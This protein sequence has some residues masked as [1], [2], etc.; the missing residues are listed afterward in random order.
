MAE[1]GYNGWTNYE[2]WAVFTWLNNEET[3]Y[4]RLR[5][6]AR[7]EGPS[8]TEKDKHL[9]VWI[10]AMNPFRDAEGS[11]YSDLLPHA[12]GRVNWTAIIEAAKEE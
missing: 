3:T 11:I 10:E 2:T 8:G 1:E 7:A 5:A 9:Q 12:L 4:R 6:I